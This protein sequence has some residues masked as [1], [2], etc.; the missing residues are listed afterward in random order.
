MDADRNHGLFSPPTSAASPAPSLNSVTNRNTNLP[1]PRTHRLRPGSQ[2]EIA[3]IN[4][5]DDK[6]LRITR[7]YAKKFSNSDETPEKDDTPGYTTYDEFIADLD[8]LVDVVWISGTRK[9]YTT[10]DTCY[11]F[12][13][14]FLLE[15]TSNT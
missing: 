14:C 15:A 7:R 9:L 8:P 5:L 2:K 11:A 10:L 4:Y 6:I 12:C 1:T 3:L 13:G